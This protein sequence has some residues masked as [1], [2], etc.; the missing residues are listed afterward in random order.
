VFLKN[1]QA[2]ATS[3]SLK[4][5]WNDVLDEKRA[6]LKERHFHHFLLSCRWAYPVRGT[7]IAEAQ[8]LLQKGG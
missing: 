7:I 1:V 3:T 2:G 5:Y 6:Y 8:N 4:Y